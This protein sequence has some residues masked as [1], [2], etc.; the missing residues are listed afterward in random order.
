MGSKL[1]PLS[2]L[3][4]ATGC[5]IVLLHHFRKSGP[6]SDSDEQ[7]ALEEL[8]QSGVA[9]WARQWLLLARRSAYKHDGTHELWMRCG[10]SA[11]HA[12]LYGI[13]IDEGTI[14]EDFDGR[15]WDVSVM[16]A[17]DIIQEKRDDKQRARDDAKRQQENTDQRAVIEAMSAKLKRGEGAFP[18]KLRSMTGFANNRLDRV[19]EQLLDLDVIEPCEALQAPSH[20]TPKPGAFRLT[21]D[22]WNDQ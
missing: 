3:G 17:H 18:R 20:K 4:Q 14:D 8:S 10:G 5:T 11:G 2:E 7:V 19:V 15:K 13:D 21:E 1:L 16:P 12:G 6:G 9:E 22:W